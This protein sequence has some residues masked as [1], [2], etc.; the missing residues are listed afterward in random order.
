VVFTK[1]QALALLNTPPKGDATIILAH[2][3]IAAKLN[4]A[5]GAD[6]TDVAQTIIDADDWLTV[7]PVGTNPKGPSRAIGISLSETLDDYNNGLIGPG[8]CDDETEEPPDGEPPPPPPPGGDGD[9]CTFT[10]GYWKTHPDQWPT[11]G[12]TLGGVQYTKD[13]ALELLNTPPRGDA[14]IILARQL[15]AAKLNVENGADETDAADAIAEGDDL[16]AQSPPGSDP[17]GRDRR[18]FIRT[19]ETLDDYN[20]GIIGPGHCDGQGSF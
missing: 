15:I 6:P 5:N 10:I 14:T 2:Q 12:L 13:E 17:K 7:N 8:H 19:A 1:A 18:V 16:L 3:L 4:I 20:N 11:D 9:G